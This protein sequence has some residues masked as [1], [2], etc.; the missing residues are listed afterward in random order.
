MIDVLNNQKQRQYKTVVI[1]I[2]DRYNLFS[3][4]RLNLFVFTISIN[5]CNHYT[6]VDDAHYK[7]DFVEVVEV[8]V[9]DIV[10]DAHIGYKPKL[11]I[12]KLWIFA[13]G[14]LEVVRMR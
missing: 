8:V 11:C 5:T 14:P 3:I 10:F 12:Y 13:E 4:L 7:A 9:L 6:A 1:H 2:F